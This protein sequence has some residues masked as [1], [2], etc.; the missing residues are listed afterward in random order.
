M[1]YPMIGQY[2][3]DY[4]VDQTFETHGRTLTETDLVN[5]CGFIGDYE[6][7]HADE[8]FA[9]KSPLGRRVMQGCLVTTA[10]EGLMTRSGLFDGTAI[11]LLASSWEYRA[12]VFIGDTVRA[13]LLVKEARRSSKGG[14]GVVTFAVVILNQDDKEVVTGSYVMMVKAA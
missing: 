7:P 1:P 14:R 3:D 2:F 10:A 12:P 11:T 8:T 5:F 13:R 6:P 9:R 4:T